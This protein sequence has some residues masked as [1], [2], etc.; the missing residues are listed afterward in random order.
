MRKIAFTGIELT[1]HVS[2]GYEVTSELPGRPATARWESKSKSNNSSIRYMVDHSRF[3][4]SLET[5]P[6]LVNATFL[7]RFKTLGYSTD[8][9]S[10]V[11]V[12]PTDL[13]PRQAPRQINA[14]HKSGAYRCTQT[15]SSELNPSR[16][17]GFYPLLQGQ[18]S[19]LL[20]A[21]VVFVRESS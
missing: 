19:R 17:C 18:T 5:A 13:F 11:S 3:L 14:L 7:P 2:E 12:V 20:A 10:A 4:D 16:P 9:N 6:I 21:M 8:S 15:I 1:S